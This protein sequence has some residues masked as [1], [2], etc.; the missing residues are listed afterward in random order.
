MACIKVDADGVPYWEQPTDTHWDYSVDWQA[1][2]RAVSDTVVSA[3]W[4][5]LTSGIAVTSN[6]FT[7]SGM[8]TGW[9]SPSAGNAGNSYYLVSKIFTD[10]GRTER[11]RLK[12]TVE[13]W[14]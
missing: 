9:V 6:V 5:A 13:S 10:F 2:I 7:A 1:R 12:I 3:V 11:Q 14:D 8:H 4:S